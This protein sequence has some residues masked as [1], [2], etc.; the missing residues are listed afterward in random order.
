MGRLAGNEKDNGKPPTAKKK[1]AMDDDGDIFG[2]ITPAELAA[3]IA[4]QL[5]LVGA[6]M[7][8]GGWRSPVGCQWPA[9]AVGA[10]GIL[11]IVIEKK[12]LFNLLFNGRRGGLR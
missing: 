7:G 3:R 5:G 4:R 8:C 2:G 10:G 11:V 9:K 1:K 12:P 6:D